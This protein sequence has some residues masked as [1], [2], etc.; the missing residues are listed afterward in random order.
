MSG[1]TSGNNRRKEKKGKK[2][3]KREKKWR[4][5]WN[6]L[7]WLI[8][9]YIHTAQA[10]KKYKNQDYW[11]ASGWKK[12]KILT[13]KIALTVVL[14][15]SNSRRKRSKK[16]FFF[17]FFAFQ[18]ETLHTKCWFLNLFLF[19]SIFNIYFFLSVIFFFFLTRGWLTHF[20]NLYISFF[21]ISLLSGYCLY[22]WKNEIC[23]Y[24]VLKMIMI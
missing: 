15:P 3:R 5:N 14:C 22:A 8:C 11:K 18:A 7:L 19:S 16:W 2:N 24:D 20:K 13:L 21:L 23:V 4:W 10:T 1:W 12:R 17:S 6:W 9:I